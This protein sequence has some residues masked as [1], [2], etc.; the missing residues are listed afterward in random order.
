[1]ESG[2]R[3]LLAHRPAGRA[4]NPG[5][6]LMATI[7]SEHIVQPALTPDR[8]RHKGAI[9]G[10]L[11]PFGVL[12]VAMYLVPV[13]YAVYQSFL[14]VERTTAFGPPTTVFGGFE[15]YKR[16]LDSNDFWDSVLRVIKLM[17]VQAPIMLGLALIFAL[18]LDSPLVKGKRFLRLA[19]FVPYAVPGVIAAIMWGFMYAPSL[20][21]FPALAENVD[22]LGQSFVL[23]SIAN[24]LTWTYTGYNMLI[25]YSA[26]QA[27]PQDL[28]EAAKVDGAGAFRVAW[29]I[30]IP[31]ILPA[32]IL[33]AVF[34][35]IG[36]MQLFN[37]PTVFRSITGSV[38]NT[39]TPNMAVYAT[40]NI[41][42]YNL[43]AAFSVVLALTTAVLS[44]AFLKLTQRRAFQ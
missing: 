20:S 22:F 9:L 12:F 41:P 27:I 30:K 21:P 26:L 33:T 39:F 5:E 32:L 37:E 3:A 40:S 36:L 13:G 42:N 24:V 35:I 23:W 34:S 7:A 17:A 25:L 28:Y 8:V 16:V 15:Q 1:M 2:G 4:T 44:F 11:A 10:F 38:S 18:L 19:F 6:H 43:A 31:L 14:K 29:S